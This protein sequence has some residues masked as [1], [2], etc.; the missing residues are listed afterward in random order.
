M[1]RERTLATDGDL[2]VSHVPK[3]DVEARSRL[4]AIAAAA[5]ATPQDRLVHLTDHVLAARVEGEVVGGAVLDIAEGS[6]GPVG[7]VSWL[8]TSPGAQGHGVGSRLLE[9]AIEYLQ[10]EGCRAAVAVVQWSNTPSSKLFARRGFERTSSLALLRRY[11]IKQGGLVLGKSYHFM[12]VSCD[13]WCRTLSTTQSPPGSKPIARTVS[14][15]GE[16]QGVR[17]QWRSAGRFLETLLVHALLLAVVVGGVAVVSWDRT[18]LLLGGVGGALIAL[19]WL[20]YLVATA[21]D[22][23][24]WQFWSWGN[25]YPFAG[26]IA[27]FGGFLPVPGHV[28]PEQRDWSYEEALPV[29]GPAA[30]VWGLI[31]VASLAVLAGFRGQLE[32]AVWESLRV[33]LTVFVVVDLWILLWPLDGYNG[34]VVYDWNR[35]VWAVLSAGTAIALGVVYLG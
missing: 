18:A 10:A 28:A 5:F 9:E 22:S 20:P 15:P 4:E 34:R 6:D 29:L 3:A 33:T 13:L 2:A 31:L 1:Y 23:R 8:F 32:D 12:N 26:I 7:I 19:R 35:A 17:S 27:L 14:S 30:A 24:R 16:T 11:G 25:V 21:L